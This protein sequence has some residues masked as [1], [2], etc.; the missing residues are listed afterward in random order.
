MVSELQDCTNITS[1][2]SKIM[3]F[4]IADLLDWAQLKA[5][6]FRVNFR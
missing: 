3:N 1:S 6:K 2:S 5:G 4:L